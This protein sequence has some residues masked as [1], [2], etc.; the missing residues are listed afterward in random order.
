MTDEPRGR[1][2]SFARAHSANNIHENRPKTEVENQ[3]RSNSVHL[4]RAS[5]QKGEDLRQTAVR[6][7]LRSSQLSL[8]LSRAQSVAPATH[9]Q[10][11]LH[12]NIV[13]V[14]PEAKARPNWE[15]GWSSFT[16]TQSSRS[17]KVRNVSVS[18]KEPKTTK[19]SVSPLTK[20]GSSSK[21]TPAEVDTSL[22][23]P[24]PPS[25][26][27]RF[28][29]LHDTGMLSKFLGSISE[30]QQPYHQQL[31]RGN[32]ADQTAVSSKSQRSSASASKNASD[33]S[34]H[35]E[36]D[37]E[38]KEETSLLDDNN[39]ATPSSILA[40][41]EEVQAFQ[42]SIVGSV[43]K[44][45][46]TRTQRK[47][48]D[49]K[50]LLSEETPAPGQA[51]LG[52]LDYLAKIQHE[53]IFAEWTQVRLRFSSHLQSKSTAR[54]R[55]GVLGFVERYLSHG[56]PEP[57]RQESDSIP[58]TKETKDSFLLEL[59]QFGQ[60][61]LLGQTNSEQHSLPGQSCGSS[62]ANSQPPQT[63]PHPTF[64]EGEGDIY[65]EN[66]RLNISSLAQV[67]IARQSPVGH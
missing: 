15:H 63:T 56:W 16:L 49:F 46:P 21:H 48:L 43:P 30:I 44:I 23:N 1:R 54:C 66:T 11:F 13:M 60:T 6:N 20:L 57:K 64:D 29:D 40:M 35:S 58:V 50:E 24:G 37:T 41:A 53:K 4:N 25:T 9:N 19:S 12:K 22:P 3:R 31:F 51:S 47:V 32:L 55:A 27:N 38:D 59:W 2:R 45:H 34:S 61:K 14:P 52:S 65:R 42:K 67:V 39:P 17:T 5:R 18:S 36:D 10:Q 8:A 33:D 62:F 26:E 7:G 28:D